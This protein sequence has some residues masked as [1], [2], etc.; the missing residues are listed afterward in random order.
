MREDGIFT[1]L[2]SYTRVLA[3]HRSSYVPYYAYTDDDTYQDIKKELVNL[4]ITALYYVRF[5]YDMI[6]EGWSY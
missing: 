5:P 4:K 6:L 3:T 2:L 1:R